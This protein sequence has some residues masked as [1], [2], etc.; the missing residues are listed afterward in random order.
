[1]SNGITIT[2]NPDGS[3]ALNVDPV[4]ELHEGLYTCVA[5]ATVP[6]VPQLIVSNEKA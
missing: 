5:M 6:D 1:M 2:N 4:Q 3:L